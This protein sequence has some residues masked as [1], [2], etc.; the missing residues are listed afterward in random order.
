M[1]KSYLLQ[2]VGINVGSNQ[3]SSL[4]ELEF[5]E[6]S[7]PRGVVVTD[8]AGIS[9]RFQNRIRFEDWGK[10]KLE[11]IVSVKMFAVASH[12]QVHGYSLRSSIKAPAFH[13]MARETRIELFRRAPLGSER[14]G[15]AARRRF[16]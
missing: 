1:D 14:P 11:N 3:G 15:L 4:F 7:E 13:D 16:T 8:R 6:F 9:E 12:K 10:E 2:E 5:N